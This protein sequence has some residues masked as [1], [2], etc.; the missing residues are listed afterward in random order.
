MTERPAKRVRAP[1]AGARRAT[2]KQPRVPLREQ[3]ARAKFIEALFDSV[4]V[5]LA[6]R[7]PD[8]RFLFV[9]RMWERYFDG[10]RETVLGKTLREL[11]PAKRAATAGAMDQDALARG[12]GTELTNEYVQSGRHYTQTRTVMADA[13]GHVIGVLVASLDTTEKHEQDEAL[14]RSRDEIADRM[15]FTNDVID[16]IPMA[17]SMRDVDGRYALVNRA[18]E[19]YYG[20]PREKAIGAVVRDVLKLSPEQAAPRD[21]LDR[22]AIE[23][24]PENPLETP[25]FQYGDRH[26]TSRRTAMSDA[27][28]RPLGV[29]LATLDVTERRA[30]EAALA[31][32]QRQLELVVRAAKTGI[33]DWDGT[34]RTVYYSP[35]FREMLGYPPDADTSAWPDYFEIIHPDDAQRVL[36]AFRAHILGKGPGGPSEFH[37]PIEYRL[38]CADGRYV[39]VEGVGVSVRDANGHATRFIASMTDITDRR[40]QEEALRASRDQI[41]A[42]AAQLEHQNEELKES[43]RLREEVERISRHDIKTPLNSV[44]AVPRLLREERRLDPEEAELLSIVERAGY[45]IL[46]MVNL[47]LDLFKM[48]QGT[49]RFRPHVVD[50][51]QL[52]DTVLADVRS[53]AASK[54]VS[55]RIVHEGRPAGETHTVH[56]WAEELLSTRSWRT[57]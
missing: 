3:A 35:R 56:A 10:N 34:T 22:A 37:D 21:A 17:V 1:R 4:P 30:M 32:E 29:V 12:P 47:S 2:K 53:H 54:Y 55:L 24:G 23:A 6:L 31:N 39:W 49:Y 26:Y 13:E 36:T 14:R 48:E 41:A 8:G 9:N 15:K 33:L 45:R 42:Q 51:V 40:T 46:N 52:L 5:A 44:I 16:S 50:L 25:D 18:W 27:Q 28:G 57:C 7:D 38:R 19:R 11:I 43:V 20:V